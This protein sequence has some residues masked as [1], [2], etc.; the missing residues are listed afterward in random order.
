[1]YVFYI[2]LGGIFKGTTRKSPKALWIFPKNQFLGIISWDYEPKSK[3]D[4][5]DIKLFSKK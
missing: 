5:N 3:D 1:M 4:G 2:L